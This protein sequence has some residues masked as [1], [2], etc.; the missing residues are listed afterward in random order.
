VYVANLVPAANGDTNQAAGTRFL[1]Q[2][3]R[4]PFIL[5]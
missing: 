2:S 4:S 5:G 1:S 3:E